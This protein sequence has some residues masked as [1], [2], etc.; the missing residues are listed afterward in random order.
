MKIQGKGFVNLWI[1]HYLWILLFSFCKEE[2]KIQ[3]KGSLD[4]TT[5]VFISQGRVE[6]K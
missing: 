3:R 1:L 4:I 6:N 5:I 2:I